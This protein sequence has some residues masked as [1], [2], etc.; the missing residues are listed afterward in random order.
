MTDQAAPAR[1]AGRHPSLH[2]PLSRRTPYDVR[3]WFDTAT[4]AEARAYARPLHRLRMLN[5]ALTSAGLVIFTL[6]HG[7]PWAAGLVGGGWPLRLI[8]GAV[9]LSVI[10]TL[11][12]IPLSAY[13]QL[14]YDKRWGLS[15]QTPRR[16]VTDQ[17]K[18]MVI[19]A[20]LLSVLLLPVYAAIRATGAWWAYGWLIFMVISLVLA[21]VFPVVIMPRFNR[22]TPMPDGELRSTIEA[23]AAKAGT[24]IQGVY[25]MDGSRRSTRSNAFVAGFGATKRVVVLDTMLEHPMATVEQVVA[26]EIGHYRR[27]HILLSFPFQAVLVLAAFA[28]LHVVGTWSWA[29]DRAGVASLGDPGSLAL[30]LLVFGGALGVLQIA[31]AW[32]TRFLEREADLEALELLGDPAAFID[33][34]RRLAPKDKAEL[35]PSWWTRLRHSHPEIAERM[36]FGRAWARSNGVALTDES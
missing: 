19:G 2:P 4:L 1:R 20:V 32:L 5:T 14:V 18:Q 34:W 29:L 26:H 21:F 22:F 28:I 13:I 24:S 36:A 8:V 7:G 3:E 31:T 15:N 23:V 11:V 17:I 6:A 33:V 27:H 16:F 25:T 10:G 30:F 12:D 35:E 9:V